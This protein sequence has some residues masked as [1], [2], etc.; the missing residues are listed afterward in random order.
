MPT[1]TYKLKDSNGREL[2]SIPSVLTPVALSGVETNAS[3]NKNLVTVESTANLFPGMP[4]AIPGMPLGCFIHSILSST[5]I[6][7]WRSEFN[8]ATGV[9]TTSAA[10][11]DA[12]K[13]ATGQ[14]GYAYGYHPACVIELA[15]AMGMWRN[16]HSSNTANGIPGTLT[17]TGPVSTSF[18][19]EMTYDE[20]LSHDT[21]GEGVAIVPTTGTFASGLY[22][23][24]AGDVR[25]S[26]TL[27]ATPLKRHNGELHGLRPFV[28]TS[29]LLSHIAANP[30][31]HVFLS[32]I[33]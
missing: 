2:C 6:E 14:T 8:R 26:D 11:A 33:A 13:T 19:R 12:T 25:T 30:Q 1:A 21:Y 28:H 18:T 24:T 23:M 10:N 32:S 3:S 4:V 7:L 22:A 16:L 31:H 9:W 27:A 15:Y 17:D 20:Q 5:Q 29:G